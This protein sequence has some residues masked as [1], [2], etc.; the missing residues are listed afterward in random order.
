M[1]NKTIFWG[2]STLVSIIVVLLTCTTFS[3]V[4]GTGTWVL[5]LVLSGVYGYVSLMKF[6]NHFSYDG[7]VKRNDKI[8]TFRQ[9]RKA[10]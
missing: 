2:I 7:R 5:T 6:I 9:R 3:W 1:K 10:S 8:V 4:L